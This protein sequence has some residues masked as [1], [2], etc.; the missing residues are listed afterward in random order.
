[1]VGV[2]SLYFAA[3]LRIYIISQPGGVRK[4]VFSKGPHTEVE[5]DDLHAR[6]RP[7]TAAP[8]TS[9]AGPSTHRQ[10]YGQPRY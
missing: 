6:N 8:P 7:S 3:L 1:M 4:F 5:Q 9:G 10:A 2:Y